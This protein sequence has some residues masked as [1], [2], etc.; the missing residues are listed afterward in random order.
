MSSLAIS[1]IVCAFAKKGQTVTNSLDLGTAGTSIHALS[2]SALSDQQAIAR[3][4]VALFTEEHSARERRG[5]IT[6]RVWKFLTANGIANVKR[7]AEDSG[8]A[9]NSANSLHIPVQFAL[10]IN[11]TLSGT[12][13]EK[14]DRTNKVAPFMKSVDYMNR[15]KDEHDFAAMS[16]ADFLSLYLGQF[17]QQAG[18]A[19]K[20]AALVRPAPEEAAEPEA[21]TI[22]SSA[23]ESASAVKVKGATIPG[24]LP[25]ASMLCVAHFDGTN[26]IFLPCPNAAPS[27]V[28]EMTEYRSTG[29]EEASTTAL[30]W[31]QAMTIAPA[32][33]PDIGRSSEPKRALAPDDKLNP[34]T[35]VLAAYAV[36]LLDGSTLSVANARMDDTRVLTIEPNGDV[37]T[38]ANSRLPRFMDKKTRNT[39]LERLAKPA[40]CAGYGGKDGISSVS[41]DDRIRVKFAH[42]SK[43]ALNGQLAFP[44]LTEF[45]KNWTHKVSKAFKPSAT[46]SLGSESLAKLKAE[47][48]AVLVKKQA[49]E[50][51]VTVTISDGTFGIKHGDGQTVS[52][53]ADTTGKVEARVMSSD[54]LASL[55]ALLSLNG[56]LSVEVDPEG[57]LALAV[58]TAVATFRVHIQT[59]E[60]GRD[61]RSR[62]LLE[63]VQ[64]LPKLVKDAPVTDAAPADALAA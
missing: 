61:T 55:P 12:A 39:M 28:A 42:K 22:I 37:D 33:I 15:V 3:D 19:A 20:L 47:H 9:S 40:L 51:Q 32:I 18:M 45:G 29:M 48:L 35:E 10:G 2:S 57:M 64:A 46:A 36:Y 58:T 23:L 38:K 41:N 63:R 13:V 7:H 31:H 14:K 34:S 44:K 4:T 59:L 16:D 1:P 21:I 62:K 11:I 5:L 54:L 43:S 30:F 60:K 56:D 24:I 25:S 52:L 6:L 17:G 26:T 27:V 50:R 49:K 53:S 8:Y